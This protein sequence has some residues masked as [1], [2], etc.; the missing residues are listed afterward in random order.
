[1]TGIKRTNSVH[2]SSDGDWKEIASIRLSSEHGHERLAMELVAEAVKDQ[3]PPARLEQ[4]KTAVAEAVLNAIEHGTQAQGD[5]SVFV[6]VLAGPNRICVRI[7]DLG[8][9]G[10]INPPEKPDIDRKL[11]GE[12][13]P[14]GWGLFLIEN[15]VDELNIANEEGYHCLE[16]V[17]S[18]EDTEDE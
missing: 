10:P 1:M 7:I 12:Q 11:A 5:E 3:L 14:R 17:M 13:S 15:M 8:E 9:G 4:L 2:A 6:Q 16:L 18:V